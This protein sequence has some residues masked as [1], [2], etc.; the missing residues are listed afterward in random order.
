MELE[1]VSRLGVIVTNLAV[2]NMRGESFRFRMDLSREV[3]RL[4]FAMVEVGMV[5]QSELRLGKEI[6]IRYI[7]VPKA[8]I[9]FRWVSAS[10]MLKEDKLII[11]FARTQWTGG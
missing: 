6:T 4:R 2:K 1:G 3:Q 9:R 11:S 10:D 7:A 8:K 5:A